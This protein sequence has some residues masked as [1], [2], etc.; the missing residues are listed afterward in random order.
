MG[1]DTEGRSATEPEAGAEQTSAPGTGGGVAGGGC[2]MLFGLPFLLAG[3]AVPFLVTDEPAERN[4]GMPDWMPW[5]FGGVFALAGAAIMVGGLVTAITA[6]GT[7]RLRRAHPDEPWRWRREWAS[8]RIEPEGGT[9]GAVATWVFALLWLGISVPIAGM[10]LSD[11]DGDMPIFFQ[12]VFGIG[13]PL[14]G[15]AILV[16]AVVL[17]A[18]RLKWGKSWL[19]LDAMPATPGGAISGRV[20]CSVDAQLEPAFT[21]AARCSDTYTVRSGKNSTQKTDVLWSSEYRCLAERSQTVPGGSL[22]PVVF[23]LPA[24]AQPCGPGKGVV[25]WSVEVSCDLPGLDYRER[26]TVPVFVAPSA[27]TAATAA[28]RSLRPPPPHVPVPSVVRLERLGSEVRVTFPPAMNPGLAT[29]GLAVAGTLGWTAWA[30]ASAQSWVGA[31]ICGA[32]SALVLWPT[33]RALLLTTVVIAAPRRLAVERRMFT[34][35]SEEWTGANLAVELTTPMTSGDRRWHR[36]RLVCDGRNH[37]V[38]SMIGSQ[39]EAEL[40]R[41]ALRERLGAS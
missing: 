8:G 37:D 17:T 25:A 2:L 7:S 11:K 4:A 13:F 16:H 1:M 33:L 5:V 39:A 3:L 41:D 20:D 12:G 34:A 26:F 22:V 24:D 40:L 27:A 31:T 21:V 19:T 30:Y 29:A 18:R 10:L 14:I 9:G 15:A 32:L 28:A 6:A 38:G 23:P 36:L 35:S